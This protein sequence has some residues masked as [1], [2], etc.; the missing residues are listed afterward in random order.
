MDGRTD[1][2]TYFNNL[3]LTSAEKSTSINQ[4]H[5][6]LSD[7]EV[8]YVLQRMENHKIFENLRQQS[9]L[10]S[11]CAFAPIKSAMP[12]NRL[13]IFAAGERANAQLRYVPSK[14]LKAGHH[15]LT[16]GTMLARHYILAGNGLT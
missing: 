3:F 8:L 16:G 7:Y 13:R 9:S 5:P 14:N 11:P 15:R 1:R 4:A 2:K 10:L 12:E 6:V